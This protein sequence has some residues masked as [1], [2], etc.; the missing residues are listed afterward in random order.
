MY[1]IVLK[2]GAKLQLI[3]FYTIDTKYY[4]I[5]N[6]NNNATPHCLYIYKES[7][8]ASISSS[9][10]MLFAIYSGELQSTS[11]KSYNIDISKTNCP[12]FYKKEKNTSTSFAASIIK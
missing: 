3:F 1:K 4:F 6:V 8:N 9:S 2:T 7:A 12:T 11:M 10:H 5:Q